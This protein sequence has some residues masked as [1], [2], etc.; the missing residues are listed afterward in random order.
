MLAPPNKLRKALVMAVGALSYSVISMLA[1]IC[2]RKPKTGRKPTTIGNKCAKTHQHTQ[3][4]SISLPSIGSC[5][6]ASTPSPPISS[7]LP[8]PPACSAAHQSHKLNQH[9]HSTSLLS[10]CV[11]W[12]PRQSPIKHPHSPPLLPRPAGCPSSPTRL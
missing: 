5:P 7:G 10:F 6:H 11:A 4:P 8:C 2:A 1:S 3:C 12:Q 9:G